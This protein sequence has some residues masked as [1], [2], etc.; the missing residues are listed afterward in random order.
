MSRERRSDHLGASETEK[1]FGSQRDV[2]LGVA[3]VPLVKLLAYNTGLQT[4]L[5]GEVDNFGSGVINRLL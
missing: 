2:L 3:R 1:N 5:L 4:I